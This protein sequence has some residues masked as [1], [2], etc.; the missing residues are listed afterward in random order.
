MSQ[1]R[2]NTRLR[3]ARIA[4]GYHSQQALADALGVG[5]R[6]VRRWE[7]STPPWPHPDLQAALSRFLG[8]NMEELGF[9]PPPGRDVGG[10]Q[11]RSALDTAGKGLATVPVRSAATMQPASV[12]ADF[13]AVTRAHRSLYWSVAPTVLYPTVIGHAELGCVLLTE[14]AGLTRQSVA[15]SLSE[16]WLLAGR[17]QFFDLRESDTADETWLRGLQAAREAEDHLLGAATLAHMAFVPGWEGRRDEA[18]QRL[19]AARTYARR[20]APPPLLLA[21]LDAVEAECETR[22]GHTR[23]ALHLINHGETVL[24]TGNGQ[25]VPEWFDWFSA[26]RLAA[27]KGN[28]QLRAG[29]LPQARA[30]LSAAL[31]QLPDA[32]AKQRSVV[33]GD[34]A[35]VEAAAGM[36]EAACQYAIRALDQLERTWYATGMDRVREVRQAL[37][38]HQ[39]EE[40]VR[41]LDERLYDW[42]TTVSALAR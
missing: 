8:Q 42:S 11:P 20:G 14:T 35:A 26:P 16:S 22:A 29:H 19:V 5:V 6:Q 34:L 12:G 30:T 41:G 23:T 21:W 27:F 39:H 2:I 15:R 18:A 25:P 7:S 31:D 9:T 33:L 32:E 36:P 28:T 4:A 24:A 38:A 40:C 1:P 10:Q 3:S 13:A 17:I 37:V